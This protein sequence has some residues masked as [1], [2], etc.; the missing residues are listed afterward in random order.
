MLI[1]GSPSNIVLEMLGPLYVN[2]KYFLRTSCVE[3]SDI[4]M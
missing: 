2:A 4:K 1:T 3:A